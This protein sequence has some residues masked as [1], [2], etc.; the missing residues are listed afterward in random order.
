LSAKG[1]K[2]YRYADVLN[3]LATMTGGR[4]FPVEGPND[5]KE[6]CATIAE[7]LRWQYVL[8]FETSGRG[9]SRQRAITVEVKKRA[10]EVVTRSGYR[11][12]APARR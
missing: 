6:A 1:Q 12:T 9:A 4:Y 3:L 11:G 2:I 7:E 8:G 10:V 5:V